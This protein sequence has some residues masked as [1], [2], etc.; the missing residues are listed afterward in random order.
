MTRRLSIRQPL[1]VSPTDP[2]DGDFM[3]LGQTE[4]ASPRGIYFLTERKSYFT[5]MRLRV[6]IPFVSAD[7]PN[8]REYVG[9]VIRV[10]TRED[11]KL[12]IAV[13]YV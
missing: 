5:G 10:D 3:D 9:Q 2:K 4:N 7:N 12:G 13:Q 11:G 6:T 8:N 1:K